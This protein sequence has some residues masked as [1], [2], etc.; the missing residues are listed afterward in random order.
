MHECINMHQI[1]ISYN[2]RVIN[3]FAVL[4][5]F[6]NKVSYTYLF[7]KAY[8]CMH[9]C[10]YIIMHECMNMLY[11]TY[12]YHFNVKNEFAMIENPRKEV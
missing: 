3:E 12:I 4:K 8:S 2:F 5:N 11:I 7:S 10:I 9:A 1:T 6:R